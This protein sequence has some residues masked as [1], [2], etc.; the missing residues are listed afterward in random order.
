MK[1]N[2]IV[3]MGTPDFAV[4]SLD[5]LYENNFNIELVITQGD[6]RRGRGKKMQY[7]PVKSRALD[8]NLEVYQ[9]EDVNS[10]ETIERL[11]DINPDF[12]VVVAFGQILKKEMLSIPKYKCINV[13][14]SLL[15]KYRGAAPI[16]WAIMD[17]ERKTGISIM[18]IG[19]GLDTGNIM[20]M[21]TIPIDDEDDYLSLHDKLANLGA[22]L[23]IETIESI[24]EDRHDNIVQDD[25]LSSYASMLYKDTGKIDWN[26]K[27]QDI[28]NLI[29]AL[30]PWPVA[31]TKYKDENFKIYK[32]RTIEKINDKKPGTIVEVSDEEIFINTLDSTLVVEE[33][34]FPNKKRM[35]AKD[36][37]MGND[38][39]IDTILS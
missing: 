21:R 6:R 3:F 30:V 35:K 38:I 34:Q 18:E 13:H 25:N 7:T 22:S 28:V 12:I 24:K 32:A 20:S 8:L 31:Q 27:G 5:A 23:L 14:A 33:L 10:N 15:P 1:K 9:P 11:K 2:N 36:Y 26:S 16:N 39:E 37:L 29:K 19:E 17:G 4:K